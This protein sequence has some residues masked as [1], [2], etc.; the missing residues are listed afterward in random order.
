MILKEV[1]ND[2]EK[3]KNFRVIID[4]KV[5]KNVIFPEYDF[6]HLYEMLDN[7][8]DDYKIPYESYEILYGV[9]NGWDEDNVICFYSH[10]PGLLHNNWKLAKNYNESYLSELIDSE[11]EKYENHL[12][13]HQEE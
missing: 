6:I 8:S 3:Y 4:P 1:K 11:K 12:K 7:K 10:G 5:N 9:Y 2:L 13:T